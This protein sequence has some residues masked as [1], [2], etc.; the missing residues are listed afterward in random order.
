MPIGIASYSF[1]FS[2]GWA[3]RHGRPAFPQPIRAPDLIALAVDHGLCGIEIPLSSML[4]DLSN[5][6]VDQ[7]RE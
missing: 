7:L 5:S 2:C 6:S 3:N 4:P 1:P